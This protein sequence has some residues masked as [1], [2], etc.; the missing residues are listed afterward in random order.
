VK[1]EIT[2]WAAVLWTTVAALGGWAVLVAALSRWLG[3]LWAKRILQNESAKFS[4]R[5]AAITHEFGLQKS[6]YEQHLGLL[7]DYY[8][9]FY[10][11]Y[12][13]C[14]RA[15]N[16]DAY[17]MPDGELVGTKDTFF[18]GLEVFLND[19][20]SQE[21]RFRLLLPSNLLD[22][23][24]EAIDCFNGFKDVMKSVQN[25]EQSKIRKAEAFA[26][27]ESV[28]QRIERDLRSFLRTEHLLRGS[29]EI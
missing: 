29:G 4:Q 25:D 24:G 13:L 9:S 6:S 18:E 16:A 22:L 26:R 17:R 8:S 27:I 1:L 23:H 2:D 12:R 5:L 15:A 7:L 11:H 14:Q 20:R 28:K 19:L 3:E 21:G 10:R